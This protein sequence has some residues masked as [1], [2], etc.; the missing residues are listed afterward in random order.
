MKSVPLLAGNELN[1]MLIAVTQRNLDAT[2]TRFGLTHATIHRATLSNHEATPQGQALRLSLDLCATQET[3]VYR[4]G[5]VI[6]VSLRISHKKCMFSTVVLDVVHGDTTTQLVVDWPTEVEMIQRRAFERAIPPS[7]RA[8]PVRFCPLMS[9]AQGKSPRMRFGQLENI[10]VGGM[11]L[12]SAEHTAPSLGTLCQCIIT[13]ERSVHAIT[14][15][16]V[17]RHRKTQ[18][19]NRATIGIQFVGLE[20]SEQRET[21]SHLLALI[22]QW[23][24]LS[25]RRSR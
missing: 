5:D 23:Q 8:V 2:V 16:G 18:S 25:R 15:K 9:S 24:Q 13:P 10:S 17:T 7:H 4:L 6:G 3:T 22:K 11:Q 20:Q 19:N 1:E 14:L 21:L 12:L